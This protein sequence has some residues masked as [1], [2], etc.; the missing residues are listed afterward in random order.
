MTCNNEIIAT[1]N[2]NLNGNGNN[3]TPIGKLST[4][5]FFGIGPRVPE[6]GPKMWSKFGKKKP[7]ISFQLS[8]WPEI[9]CVTIFLK[10]IATSKVNPML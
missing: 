3:P 5:N 8:D 10:Y 7:Y 2:G 9:W 6:I 1:Q 4:R